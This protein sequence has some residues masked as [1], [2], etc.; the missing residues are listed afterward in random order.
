MKLF[1]HSLINLLINLLINTFGYFM[2]LRFYFKFLND[3]L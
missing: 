1:I 3:G 2:I